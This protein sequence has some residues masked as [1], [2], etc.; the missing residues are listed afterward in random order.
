MYAGRSFFT[1]SVLLLLLWDAILYVNVWRKRRNVR[2]TVLMSF[3]VC[4]IVCVCEGV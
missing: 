1:G 2:H 4:V 3:S